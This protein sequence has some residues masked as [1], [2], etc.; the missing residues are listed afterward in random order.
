MKKQTKKFLLDKFARQH[1]RRM[2]ECNGDFTYEDEL[3]LAEHYFIKKYFNERDYE[4]LSSYIEDH[5]LFRRQ[6]IVE[7]REK[8]LKQEKEN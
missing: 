2:K 5:V 8:L 6:Q 1:E 4:S 3:T 7:F